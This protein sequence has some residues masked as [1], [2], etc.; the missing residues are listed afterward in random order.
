MQIF[1]EECYAVWH[2]IA[3]L[4]RNDDRSGA[5]V[6]AARVLPLFVGGELRPNVHRRSDDM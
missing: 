4:V 1:S 2:D 3:N 6:L 5:H